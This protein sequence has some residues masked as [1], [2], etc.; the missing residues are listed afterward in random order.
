MKRRKK[1]KRKRKKAW[2]T[3]QIEIAETA[4]PVSTIK[5]LKIEAKVEV[6]VMAEREIKHKY[7]AMMHGANKSLGITM[8]FTNLQDQLPAE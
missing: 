5:N 7:Q 6:E 4:V 2:K 1:R 3:L 8:K